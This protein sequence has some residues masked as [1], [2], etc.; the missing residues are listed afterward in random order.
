[1]F[2]RYDARAED[3]G[4]VYSGSE[5]LP[6]SP[7]QKGYLLL[8][9]IS[10]FTAFLEGTE[11]DHAQ[12][13]IENVMRTIIGELTP[14][15]Q[16]AEVEGDAVFVYGLEEGV[17]R[18]ELI[19]ELVDATYTAFRDLRRTMSRNAA[20]PC[21]ACQS[22]D[23]LDLKF[24]IHFGDFVLQDVT[25]RSKPLGSSVNLAH[26]LLKNHVTEQTGWHAYALFSEATLEWMGIESHG[27]GEFVEEY[28]HLGEVRLFGLDLDGRY[29]DLVDGRRVQVDAED[30][31][32]SVLRRF[33]TSPA[34]T[35]DWFNDPV[36]RSRWMP[37]SDWHA[38]ARPDGRTG[39]GAQNHCTISK[40]V[41]Q[42][43][44][45]HPFDY[46]TVRFS[47]G[48]WHLLSTVEFE[49]FDGGTEVRWKLQA[50]GRLPR[51]LLVLACHGMARYGIELD[52]ALRRLTALLPEPGSAHVDT[53]S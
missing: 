47:K 6:V 8:A 16:L 30:S 36:K 28:D 43:L 50:E 23:H 46:Y 17:T 22:I 35:W 21:R 41:E 3:G 9:D 38:L 5:C 7:I 33:G 24:V 51:P 19:F 25:G 4:L 49:P 12:G 40:V 18:G 45:W 11:L 1:M 52:E 29:L 32:I 48:P 15:L 42:V 27:M 20:C 44:D 13:V 10:G 53:P 26:R 37:G 31:H 34:T 2:Y 39:R 14:A